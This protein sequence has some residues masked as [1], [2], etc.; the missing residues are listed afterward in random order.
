[1]FWNETASWGAMNLSPFQQYAK[2][3]F[4]TTQANN[5]PTYTRP[6]MIG[7][8]PSLTTAIKNGTNEFL[9]VNGGLV[10]SQSGKLATITGVQD[11]GNL[12]LGYNNDTYFAGDIAEVLVY[13][14]A[15]SDPERQQ[16]EQYLLDKYGIEQTPVISGMGISNLTATAPRSTGPPISPP[17]RRSTTGSPTPMAVRHRWRRPPSLLIR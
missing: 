13:N 2:Y 3:R 8:A 12:G 16:V 17:T 5:L 14:R 7:N 11:T 4:G 6:R 9:Y 10:L 1:M 15:L